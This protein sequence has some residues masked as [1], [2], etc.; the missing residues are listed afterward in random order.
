MGDAEFKRGRPAKWWKRVFIGVLAIVAILWVL[1]TFGA[2]PIE[3]YW[4]GP[5]SLTG[6]LDQ[7]Y[8][9]NYVEFRNGEASLGR[10]PLPGEFCGT[11]SAVAGGKYSLIVETARSKRTGPQYIVTVGLFRMTAS[12]GT[13]SLH[14]WRVPVSWLSLVRWFWSIEFRPKG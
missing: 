14:A 10:W 4:W 5:H 1:D 2:W 8:L 12:D 13:E 6:S 11:Y 3:G 9:I 7:F